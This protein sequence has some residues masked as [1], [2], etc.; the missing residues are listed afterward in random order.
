[1]AAA[2]TG[3]SARCVSVSRPV[4][5]RKQWAQ[6][7]ASYS[8]LWCRVIRGE[9]SRTGVRNLG[10]RNWGESSEGDNGKAP[11]RRLGP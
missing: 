11:A 6:W 8:E 7:D 10:P 4:A 1:V 5:S 2:M 9:N 3:K